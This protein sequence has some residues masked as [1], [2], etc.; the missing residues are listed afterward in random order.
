MANIG[1]TGVQPSGNGRFYSER[2]CTSNVRDGSFTV[3]RPPRPCG[4]KYGVPSHRLLV[5]VRQGG[6]PDNE[7]NTVHVHNDHHVI[8]YVLADD[9]RRTATLLLPTY[10]YCCQSLVPISS[11][12]ARFR[13]TTNHIHIQRREEK[14]TPSHMHILAAKEGVMAPL[15]GH[16][17]GTINRHTSLLACLPAHPIKHC[18]ERFCCIA[19]AS[20]NRHRAPR[21]GS[22]PS[23]I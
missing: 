15:A 19:F 17:K 20:W 8:T 12:Q 3:T 16:R 11:R 9:A 6:G 10:S 13:F 1:C 18:T 4:T 2:A 21:S 14:R 5:S 7:T 22:S 23:R